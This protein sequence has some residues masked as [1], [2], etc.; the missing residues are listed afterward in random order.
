MVS[1]IES[2]DGYLAFFDRTRE[3]YLGEIAEQD[4][5]VLVV[6]AQ[7]E[8]EQVAADIKVALGAWLDIKR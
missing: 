2:K 6:N 1:S 3:R 4:E 7:Q 5:T 8:V